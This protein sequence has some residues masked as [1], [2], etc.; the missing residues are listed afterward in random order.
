MILSMNNMEDTKEEIKPID[1]TVTNK[2]QNTNFVDI[3]FYPMLKV[4]KLFVT[5]ISS[6][7]SS[8]Y[9]A[10]ANYT[11]NTTVT[12]TTTFRP[13]QVLFNGYASYTNKYTTSTGFAGRTAPTAGRNNYMTVEQ[14]TGVITMT[15]GTGAYLGGNATAYCYVSSWTETGIVLTVVCPS[16]WT[17]STN[18]QIL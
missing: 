7:I 8:Q 3:P 5:D 9:S 15:V 10:T 4:D 12:I 2:N 18:L 13:T 6:N 14:G 11:S 17:L 16:G 1:S